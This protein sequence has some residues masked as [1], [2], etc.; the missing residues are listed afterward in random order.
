MTSILKRSRDAIR[1]SAGGLISKSLDFT[2]VSCSDDI[3]I[4]WNSNA[5]TFR[6]IALPNNNSN[7]GAPFQ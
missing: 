2:D 1:P 4:T 5:K 3:A 7:L 6:F